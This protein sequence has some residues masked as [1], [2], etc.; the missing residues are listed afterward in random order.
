MIAVNDAICD[1]NLQR[2]D[3][4]EWHYINKN[5]Y[6]PIDIAVAAFNKF[7]FPIVLVLLK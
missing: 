6:T 5:V 1:C 4:A 7:R 2:C 3:Q